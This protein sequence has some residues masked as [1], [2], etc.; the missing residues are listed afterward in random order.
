[1]SNLHPS[2]DF[3]QHPEDYIPQHPEDYIPQHPALHL[4]PA[5]GGVGD[6]IKFAKWIRN[7]TSDRGDKAAKLLIKY[8]KCK[9]EEKEIENEPDKKSWFAK[10][11]EKKLKVAKKKRRK[12]GD[13]LRNIYMEVMRNK[14]IYD[15][16]E[17][18]GQPYELFYADLRNELMQEGVDESEIDGLIEMFK[19][20]VT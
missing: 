17:D 16:D 2:V 4:E 20:I 5:E 3:P 11:K 18:D 8:K 1:M 10:S 15:K 12:I 13:K 9:D 6:L 7:K 14:K 19:D